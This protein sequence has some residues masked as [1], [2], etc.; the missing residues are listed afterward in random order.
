MAA[1]YTHL[2]IEGDISP[3][4]HLTFFTDLHRST[5]KRNTGFPYSEPQL[6][7]SSRLLRSAM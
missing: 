4:P 2:Q 6:L 5:V 3:R 1:L 7:V